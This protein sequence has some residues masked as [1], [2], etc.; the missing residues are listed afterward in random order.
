MYQKY[1]Q[2]W[3][4]FG[5]FACFWVGFFLVVGLL[6]LQH[7]FSAIQPPVE[8]LLSS[9]A[10]LV[11]DHSRTVFVVVSQQFSLLVLVHFQRPR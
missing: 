1:S 7:S 3:A 9:S 8:H 4:R 2:C 11:V 5:L 10:S 6:V